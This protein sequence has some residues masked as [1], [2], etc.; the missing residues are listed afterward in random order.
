MV[1]PLLPFSRCAGLKA[2]SLPRGAVYPSA[3][4]PVY[5]H[6]RRHFPSP[7]KTPIT[8]IG[9]SRLRGSL[10]AVR[11][12]EHRCGRASKQVGGSRPHLVPAD[13]RPFDGTAPHPSTTSPIPSSRWGRLRLVV[14]TDLSPRESRGQ[15]RPARLSRRA[16][17]C[18]VTARSGFSDRNYP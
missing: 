18:G 8:Q 15:T 9:R 13:E 4:P 10:A 14:K 12:G 3:P 7:A 11:L 6:Y 2:P 5:S 1:R 16:R 17:A